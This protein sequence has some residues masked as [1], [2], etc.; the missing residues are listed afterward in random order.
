MKLSVTGLSTI[1]V[2]SLRA[3]MKITHA[4]LA[5]VAEM[6]LEPLEEKRL[7]AVKA[8]VIGSVTF[9]SLPTQR[10]SQAHRRIEW[11]MA[12]HLYQDHKPATYRTY[13]SIATRVVGQP[14]R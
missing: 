5:P 3:D 8:L 1:A 4:V 12:T 6:G 7:E 10:R 14:G 13:S 9:V 11:T 2:S